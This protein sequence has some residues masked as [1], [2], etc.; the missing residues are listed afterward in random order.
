[1]PAPHTKMR[2]D[3]VIPLSRQAVSI[4]KDIG[5]FSGKARLVF[6]S[7]RNLERPLSENAMN[8]ALRRMG[9]DKHEH[10][11]HGFRS[12]ASTILNGRRYHSDVIEASL[13][14]LD[15]NVVRRTYNRYSYW[16][17]RVQMAQEWADICDELRSKKPRRDNSDLV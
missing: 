1:M 12:S 9:Y 10:T 2:R 14:H 8:S 15:P 3:F 4:L 11:S 7:I 6:P 5:E 13:A 17:E 16:D